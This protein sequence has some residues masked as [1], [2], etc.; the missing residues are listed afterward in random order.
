MKG[1][2]LAAGYGTRLRP[3]TCT[4]PKP[5]VP[6]CNRPLIGWAVESYLASGVEDLI[7]NLHHLPHAIERALLAQYAQR[8]SFFF[9]FEAEILGTGGALRRV[10]ALLENERDFFLVN[11]DTVQFPRFPGLA[12]ARRR[13]DALAAL[14]L[15]RPPVGDRFTPVWHDQGRLTGFGEGHGQ[16]LMFGGSHCISSRV[17]RFL[18]DRDFSGIVADVYEPLLRDG[19]DT[20]AAIVDDRLWFD[21]GTPQ[22]YLSASRAFLEATVRGEV[23]PAEGSFVRGDSLV[24]ETASVPAAL[25]RSSVGAGSS[26]NGEVEDSVIWENCTIP[27]G[28]VLESCIAGHGVAIPAPLELR[29]ALICRDDPNIPH[30]PA[31]VRRDGLVILPLDR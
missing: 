31:Y 30:D 15:R 22:R 3:L 19:T 8:A 25:S 16:S 17:F 14:T 7:V 21:I 5:L 4:L 27:D 20:L 29:N 10:R 9:S 28:V 2:I 18:P 1:V 24:H 12:D 26:V 6:L 13:P 23:A 11:G